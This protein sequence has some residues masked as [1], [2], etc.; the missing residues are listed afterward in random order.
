MTRR[1]AQPLAVGERVEWNTPQGRTRGVV[2]A[3]VV[4]PAHAG[5]HTAAAASPAEP[6]FEV[7]SDASGKTAIHHPT[8]LRKVRRRR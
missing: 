4:A 3:E 7:R 8:A 2:I 1:K 6:Q 5:G